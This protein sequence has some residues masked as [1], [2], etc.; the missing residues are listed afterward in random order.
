M[1][2]ILRFVC[3][4]IA[5]CSCI[6]SADKCVYHIVANGTN[7]TRHT[8]TS[9]KDYESWGNQAYG[10]WNPYNTTVYPFNLLPPNTGL[11]NRCSSSWASSLNDWISTV[12]YT[13][14]TD[15][16]ENT[17]F[18]S[19]APTDNNVYRTIFQTISTI[20]TD[21]PVATDSPSSGWSI[22][23]PTMSAPCCLNCTVFGGNAQ[24]YYWPT[25]GPTPHISRLVDDAGYTL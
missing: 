15:Y 3:L 4:T 19:E 12:S 20:T 18:F 21:D 11:A 25:P 14:Y 7:G 8:I 1:P 2:A 17:V 22:F 16:I 10:S 23:N 9:S 5:F 6:A 13:C 24:V